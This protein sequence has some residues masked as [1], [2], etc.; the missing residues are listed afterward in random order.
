[1]GGAKQ[2]KYRVG[3]IGCGLMALNHARMYNANPL[4]EVVAAA[5]PDEENLRAFCDRFG[6]KAAYTSAAEML[7]NERI[8]IAAALVPANGGD[9]VT[10]ED[11]Y[12][13]GFEVQIPKWQTWARKAKEQLKPS[14]VHSVRCESVCPRADRLPDSD[15]AG[16]AGAISPHAQAGRG[17]LAS[18]RESGPR[19]RVPG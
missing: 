8:D 19:P 14:A 2:A 4:T 3:A 12:R 1:M 6:I 9:P 13:R 10:P 18:V 17:V 7:A 11:V 5:D 15:A 16:P